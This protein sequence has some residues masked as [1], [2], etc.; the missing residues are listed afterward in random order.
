MSI[1][2]DA[3]TFLAEAPVRRSETH[4]VATAKNMMNCLLVTM[5]S[6]ETETLSVKAGNTDLEVSR[7]KDAP[8]CPFGTIHLEKEM[9]GE[10]SQQGKV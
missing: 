7:A 4:S 1:A 5:L 8:K 10:S 9:T 6:Y 3:A 2:R